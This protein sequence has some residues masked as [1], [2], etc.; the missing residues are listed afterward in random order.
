[1]NISVW[2]LC[3]NQS[4]SALK[5]IRISDS[6]TLIFLKGRWIYNFFPLVCSNRAKR[7]A[8]YPLVKWIA[9]VS[10][11]PTFS[12]QSPNYLSIHNHICIVATYG[13]CYLLLLLNENSYCIQLSPYI[14]IFWVQI[15]GNDILFYGDDT[16]TKELIGFAEEVINKLVVTIKQEQ[17][18]V[19]HIASSVIFSFLLLFAFS[20]YLG[21][22]LLWS[23]SQ[24]GSWS[25][26]TWSS[27][28]HQDMLQSRSW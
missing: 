19:S 25:Y 8:N 26:G 13:W 6:R 5:Y 10:S 20:Y 14:F 7:N 22:F 28:L 21:C 15:P 23:H 4:I 11:K 2:L 1:M 9:Y 12:S 17:S 27:W 24:G 16:Y 18:P 3:P